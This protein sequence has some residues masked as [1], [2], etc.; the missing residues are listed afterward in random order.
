M[1]L[2]SSAFPNA[3]LLSYLLVEVLVILD[4]LNEPILSRDGHVH[5]LPAGVLLR[6]VN[7]VPVPN[8]ESGMMWPVLRIHPG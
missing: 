1:S 3:D 2:R 7:L 4:D 5:G 6:H 8:S